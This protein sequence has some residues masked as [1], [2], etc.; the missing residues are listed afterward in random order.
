[1]TDASGRV[2]PEA[3]LAAIFGVLVTV[4]GELTAERLD[5]ELVSRLVRRLSRHGP[6]ADGASAGE[7]NAL[8]A[9]LCRRM[10][11]AMGADDEYPAP[12]PR[13]VTYQLGLPDEQAAETV[14]GQ[15]ASEGGV[16]ATFPPPAGSSAF[17]ETSGSSALEGTAGGEPACWQVKA[18]FPDLV[19]S[20]E[21][22]QRTEHLTRLA[23][24]NGGRYLGAEF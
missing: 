14:A 21:N 18:T 17:E 13:T 20:T 2:L 6:L 4:H 22:R 8:L 16:T 23:E 7:L 12:S 24:Q 5:P 9:D 3:D 15:L 11:W 10:H 1:M 19:P